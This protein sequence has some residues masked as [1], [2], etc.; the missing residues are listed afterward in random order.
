MPSIQFTREA[1]LDIED[2]I[3]WYEKQ[4]E[5]L[6]YDFELCL[7]A[8]ISEILRIPSGFQKDIKT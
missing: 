7:E 6:S 5:G 3:F 4:R 8:G 2:I 1:L